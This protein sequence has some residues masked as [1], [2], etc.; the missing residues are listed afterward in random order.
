[1]SRMRIKEFCHAILYSNLLPEWCKTKLVNIDIEFTRDNDIQIVLK[2][3][4]RDVLHEKINIG[5]IISVLGFATVLCQRYS[6][7]DVNIF[8]EVLTD[9]LIEIE[10]NPDDINE[11]MLHQC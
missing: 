8:I 6:W 11:E 4:C 3:I 10:F 1:M 5:R 7:C 9:V 2:R